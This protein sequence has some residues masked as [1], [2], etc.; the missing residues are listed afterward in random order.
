M[1]K[2]R[3]APLWRSWRLWAWVFALGF[4]WHTW[5]TQWVPAYQLP[6]YQTYVGD[7]QKEAV[8]WQMGHPFM[9]GIYSGM[10][11]GFWPEGYAIPRG[12]TYVN[13]GQGIPPWTYSPFARLAFPAFH[14]Y[15]TLFAILFAR[16]YLGFLRYALRPGSRD[17]PI[18]RLLRRWQEFRHRRRL[19]ASTQHQDSD[20]AGSI[21][22]HKAD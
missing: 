5:A 8:D 14:L 3:K 11:L 17:A 6:C 4:G 12:C 10:T 1:S 19:S 7:F 16:L 13:E 22:I 15:A 2:N 21:S 20:P 9:S 18:F